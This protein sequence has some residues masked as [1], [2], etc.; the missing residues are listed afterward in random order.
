MIDVANPILTKEMRTRMR[1]MRAFAIV[2][3]YAMTL[4]G[5]LG[6]FYW[7]MTAE[8]ASGI[9]NIGLYL[10]AVAVFVQMVLV[11]IISPSFTAT[12]ISSERE[13]QTFELLVASLA[14][15]MTILVGKVG[16]SLCYL[17]LVLLA[18]LPIISFLY[19]VGGISLLDVAVCYFVMIVSG[20]TY[21]T[22]SF[23]WSTLLR[24]AVLAQTV[25]LFSVIALVV[26]IPALTLFLQA[27]GFALL[28]GPAGT[29]N[30]TYFMNVIYMLLRTNP[31]FAQGETLFGSD[32]SAPSGVWAPW[33]PA[34]VFLTA[35]YGA[36]TLVAASLSWL[37]L[38]NA[39]RWLL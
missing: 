5:I 17:L 39:R 38:R 31:F 34:W 6:L 32:A 25:G 36:I 12:A 13:Q 23:L 1:G 29:G 9:Q 24:R 19:W 14:T 11:C 7:A 15:P 35:F 33:I 37:R 22:M 10:T 3:L 8:A 28:G 4:G 30:Q 21:C 20:V 18:S 26:G 27:V 16:A 2:T